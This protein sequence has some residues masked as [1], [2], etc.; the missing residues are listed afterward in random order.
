MQNPRMKSCPHTL[1]ELLQA[2]VDQ[3]ADSLAL[4]SGDVRLSYAELLQE[5]DSFA[6]QLRSLGIRRGERLG[7]HLHKSPQEVV[8]TLAGASLGVVF[9]NINYQWTEVQVRH[10]IG[11]CGI[12]VLVTDPR[13]AK[14][15]RNLVESGVVGSIIVTGEPESTQP[16]VVAQSPAGRP[17]LQRAYAPISTDLAALLYTSGSTGSPKGVMVTHANL[18]DGARVVSGYLGLEANDRLLSVPPLNFDYGLNQ[19]IGAIWVGATLVLQKAPLPAEIL[20]SVVAEKITVL[21]LV[22]PSWVQVLRVLMDEPLVLPALRIATNTGGKIPT[23]LLQQVEDLLPSVS[24]FLMYGL[25]EAFRSTYVPPGRFKDKLGAIG[26]SVPDNEVFVVDPEKGVCGPNEVGEL[27]HRG[28]FVSRG[29]WG[30]P[31]LSA[32]KIKPNRHLIG[33]IGDEP[34]VHSGDLVERDE[35]GFLWFVGRNDE[36]IKSSGFRMSPNEVEE[37]ACSVDGV[38]EAVAWGVPDD[39]MGQ[40][41]YLAVS[42]DSSIDGEARLSKTL[43]KLMPAYMVPRMLFIRHEPMPKTANGKINRPQIIADS[44]A[45]QI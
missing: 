21:P 2:R 13:K 23:G 44:Q 33:L 22:A 45:Q 28:C 41:V 11:D 20:K 36:M 40:V 10:V 14:G 35:D 42:V 38:A 4:V 25:T 43:R 31:E 5:V 9:V 29:Y 16:F 1:P 18:L 27:I 12:S 30:K 34:V 37:F 3:S 15:M 6:R 39:E 7:I 17:S 32:A 26:I 8:A 24:F 19:L